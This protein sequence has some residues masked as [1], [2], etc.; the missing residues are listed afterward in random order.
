MTLAEM[1]TVKFG[2]RIVL[3]N[4][5]DVFFAVADPHAG[6]RRRCGEVLAVIDTYTEKYLLAFQLITNHN[7]GTF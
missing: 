3:E 4:H 5:L 6:T 2:Q 1:A 7:E